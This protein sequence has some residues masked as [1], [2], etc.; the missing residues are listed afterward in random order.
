MTAV[1]GRGIAKLLAKIKD[2][3][4][5]KKFYEGNKNVKRRTKT[6]LKF[7]FFP[8]HQMF[9]TIY[10]RYSKQEKHLELSDLLL[11]GAEKLIAAKQFQSGSDLS[12][13]L[14]EVLQKCTFDEKEFE[15]WITNVGGL[16]GK[17]DANVVERETLIVRAVKWSCE[18]NKKNPNQGHPLIHKLIANSMVFYFLF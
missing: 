8:A 15:K 12:L 9:R 13:L 10:F 2:S 11:D 7:S 4:D 17:I 3:L 14:I 6:N 5:E 18:G 16:I 1:E